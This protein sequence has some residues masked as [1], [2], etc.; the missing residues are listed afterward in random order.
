MKTKSI[1]MI[2]TATLSLSPALTKPT[3]AATCPPPVRPV[4]KMPAQSASSP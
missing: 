1:L 3:A 4:D 2:A